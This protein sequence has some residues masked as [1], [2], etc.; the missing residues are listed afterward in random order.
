MRSL[1]ALLMCLGV[2][3]AVP[4]SVSSSSGAQMNDA[5]DVL[6]K[7]DDHHHHHQAHT[8][9]APVIDSYSSYASASAPA[10]TGGHYYY[11]HPVEEEVVEEDSK[12]KDY[13]PVDTVLAPIIVITI[14]AGI[15]AGDAVGLVPS[16]RFQL[17]QATIDAINALKP[18]PLGIKPDII[19]PANAFI[20]ADGTAGRQMTVDS[21]MTIDSVDLI[22][23]ITQIAFDQVAGLMTDVVDTEDC[24]LRIVCETGKY[25]EGRKNLLGVMHFLTP[26]IYRKKMKVFKDS[27]LKKLDCANF[28]CGY[29]EGNII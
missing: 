3:M 28:K 25:A 19:G 20:I 5:S 11:Y 14:F 7:R 29:L 23:N 24:G 10:A 2:G 8:A 6:M 26:A 22:G 18:D 1:L 9:P 13:C 17:P 16:V 21:E 15:L 27:A 4:P 12:K